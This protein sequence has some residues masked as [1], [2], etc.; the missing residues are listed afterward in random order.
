MSKLS[1]SLKIY[2]G[3]ILALAVSNAIQIYLPSY[4]SLMPG[5]AELP[6]PVQVIALINAG[7]AIFVYGGLGLLGLKLA[8]KLGFAGIWEPGVNN[9]Q[10][11]LT[12]AVIGAALGVF[13]IIADIIFSQFNGIGRFQHPAFPASIFASLSAGIGEEILFRLFFIPLWV[14]LISSLILRGKGRSPVFW[15]ISVVSALAFALGHLP[16]VMVLYGY[17]TVAEISPVLMFEIILLNGIISIFAAYYLR[18]YGFLAA[19]G[20]HFWTDIVWHVIWGIF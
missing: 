10:R 5:A 6:A 16:A 19:A 9:R 4:T 17:K 13:L 7:I 20:I 3:L 14:W 11:F 8:G 2:L 18:K 15:I 12:P 1:V